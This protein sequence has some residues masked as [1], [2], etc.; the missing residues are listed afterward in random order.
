MKELCSE[1]IGKALELGA[2]CAGIASIGDLKRMPSFRMMPLRPHIDRVGAVPNETGLPEGVVAWPDGMRSVLIIACSH[3]EEDPILDC[4]LDEKNPP[5][6]VLLASIIRRVKAWLDLAHPEISSIPM[7]YYVERGGIWLKDAAAMAGLGVIGKNNLLVTPE[8]GSRVRLRAMY[9]SMDA[10]STGP[11]A[12]DPCAGCSEP[13]RAACPQGAFSERVY[14]PDD[15]NGLQA[16]PGRSGCYDL[17]KCDLQMAADEAA[18]QKGE[19]TL[20]GYGTFH[21]VLPYCRACEFG[22]IVGRK[23]SIQDQSIQD[24][25]IRD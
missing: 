11:L 10:P 7:G 25:S 22:C 6:N 18:I 19:I 2:D 8:Y 16:L 24:Q 20:P 4:W 17:C 9:L 5:G 1:I 12:W 23:P 3:P 21:S 15:Y 13:C 14:S